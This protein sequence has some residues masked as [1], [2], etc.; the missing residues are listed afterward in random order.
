MLLAGPRSF[1]AGVERAIDIVERALDRSARRSTCVAR[2]CTT[3][4]SCGTSRPGAHASST[5]STRCPTARSVVIAAHGV[6]RR[7]TTEAHERGLHVIDATC[8]LVAKVHPEAR[9]FARDGYG[10]SWS[11]TPTTKRSQGT[12]G[13]APEAIQVVDEPEAADQVQASDPDR[14][15]YLTQTT[16]AVDEVQEV[17][18]ALRARFPRSTG[19]RADDICYATQ[20]R[21]EAVRSLAAECDLMLVVGSRNS[22]NSQPA[23]RGGRAV[24]LHRPSARG[25]VRARLTA[26]SSG[27]RDG[28]DHRRRVGTRIAGARGSSKRSPRSGPSTWSSVDIVH[29]SRC[30]SPFPW[31]CADGTSPCAR[32]SASASYLAK[33]KLAAAQAV[34]AHRRARA[35]LRLQPRVPGLRQDPVPDRDPAPPASASRTRWPRSRSAARRWCR[36]PAAS[37]CSTPTSTEM[38]QELID[39]KRFVY[40][41]TNGVLMRREARPLPAVALLQLG[42][43]H[44][45]PARAPRRRRSAATASS[46][47]R[48]RRSARPRTRGSGSRRTRPSST[49]TRPGPCARS[50]TS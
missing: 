49:P 25:R 24:R 21:Q 5:S 36:S 33:Q 7:S 31:R 45:R 9:R 1:C 17:V 22:S 39:R 41:C 46:T 37:R 10:S 27:R 48:S 40:L 11:A 4:T 47:R 43:P 18:D 23:R 38:V 44:R 42:R 19:P 32:Q 15:A 26:G 6:A 34:P 13:E 14:V 20:N 16:L 2:S 30:T 35:A 3:P 12:V 29:E 28:R 50:S 8:P